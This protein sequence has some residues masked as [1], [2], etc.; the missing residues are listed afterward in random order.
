MPFVAAKCPQCGGDLQLDSQME[1]GFCMHCGSKIT[2]QEA[3]RAVRIDNTQMVATW[4]K[5]GDL[6]AESGNNS[7]AYEYYTKVFEVQPENWWAIFKKGKAAGWQSTLANARVTET[8]I[9]FAKAIELAPEDEKGKVIDESTEDIKKLALALI[10]L[11]ADIFIKWPDVDETNGFLGDINTIQNAVIQLAN[12][13]G[14]IL[15]GYL[16]PIATLINGTVV[17]AWSQK[18]L[19]DYQGNENHPNKYEFDQ[20]LE[21]LGCCTNLIE[22]AIALSNE[23][24]KDD[25]Q[26]YE[27]LIF[28]HNQAINSCSWNCTYESW[29]PVWTKEFTL[30]ESAK[31]Y[32]RDL[33]NQ[34]NS[35]ISQIKK[36]LVEMEEIERQQIENRTSEEKQKRF[37]EYW[38]IHLSEKTELENNKISI[39]AQIMNLEKE[40]DNITSGLKI[41][42]E[43]IKAYIKKLI[44]EQQTLGIFKGNEK[45]T[46]QAQID[47]A[48]NILGTNIKKLN[49]T[50]KQN[51]VIIQD[52]KKHLD[53][54]NN[55]LTKAR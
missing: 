47:K 16:E 7:E 41:E 25:I 42:N 18:I 24:D 27:N 49:E 37:N 3:I 12:K 46:L 8:V 29:G 20:F 31:K 14:V 51:L 1:T 13:S 52:L 6:A 30:T 53:E 5:M 48:Q 50:E 19:P 21:R 38:S 39:S 15:S 54:I 23:D 45:K 28:F 26:R 34:Y 22:K 33:I 44:N 10:S 2:V 17:A 11:R 40:R 55:E 35:K 4:M 9:C 32:H 36:K 43:K